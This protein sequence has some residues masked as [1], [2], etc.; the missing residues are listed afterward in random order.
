[1]KIKEVQNSYIGDEFYYKGLKY[2]V[3]IQRDEV[4]AVEHGMIYIK[5]DIGIAFRFKAAA[6]V[7]LPTRVWSM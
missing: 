3:L 2:R 7:R 5:E 1:M 6:A 4:A